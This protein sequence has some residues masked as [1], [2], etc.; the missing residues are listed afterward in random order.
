TSVTT[1]AEGPPRPSSISKSVLLLLESVPEKRE[2]TVGELTDRLV[3]RGWLDA[4]TQAQR[5]LGAALSRMT[6]D[7]E[8][9]RVSRGRYAAAVAEPASTSLLD[10]EGDD[11]G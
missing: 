3:E 11:P 6:T 1:V 5:S 7:G 9:R 8:I 10:N 2:W 4:S